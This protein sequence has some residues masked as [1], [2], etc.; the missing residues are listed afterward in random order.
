MAATDGFR[1]VPNMSA[2]TT[3]LYLRLGGTGA[4]EAVVNGFYDRVMADPT[5]APFFAGTDMASQRR[6]LASFVAAAAGGPEYRGRSIEDAHRG[7]GIEQQQFDAV[8]A[9]LVAELDACGVDPDVVVEGVGA[10]APLA[11]VVVAR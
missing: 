11:E 6:H 8:A 1:T 3:A 2:T 4:I 9:H 10:I 5:L 7:L